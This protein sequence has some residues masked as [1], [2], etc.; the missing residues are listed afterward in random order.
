VQKWYLRQVTGDGQD[1]TNTVVAE[2]PTIGH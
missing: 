1:R 2:L